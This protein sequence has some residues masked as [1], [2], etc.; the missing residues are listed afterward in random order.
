MEIQMKTQKRRLMWHGMLLFLFG[1]ITGLLEQRFTHVRMGLSAHLEGLM[2]GI[3][4]LALGAAWNEV[5]LPHPVNEEVSVRANSVTTAE[6]VKNCDVSLL[7]GLTKVPAQQRWLTSKGL[8]T[9]TSLSRWAGN[10]V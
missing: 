6:G 9:A 3:L 7:G 2:N 5:R 10:A 4:R 8:I 1:L